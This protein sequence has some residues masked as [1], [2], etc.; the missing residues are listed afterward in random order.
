MR[1]VSDGFFTICV[2]SDEATQP[3]HLP[4][5]HVRS[6]DGDVVVALPIL[7]LIVGKNL[8]KRANTLLKNN[9]DKICDAWNK[10]NPESEI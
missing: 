7:K 10:L 5:C 9:F 1:V 4:H 2:Y 6:P 8:S 3:H